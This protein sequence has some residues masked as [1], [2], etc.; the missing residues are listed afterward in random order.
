MKK[1]EEEEQIPKG[2]EG[3]KNAHLTL[4]PLLRILRI[5]YFPN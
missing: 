5:A 1:E 3:K 2:R 4:N